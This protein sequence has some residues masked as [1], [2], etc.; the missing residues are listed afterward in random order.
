V[1]QFFDL[2]FAQDFGGSSSSFEVDVHSWPH[3][4]QRHVHSHI[5]TFRRR[6]VIPAR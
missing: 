1:F 4:S 6:I 5:V 3:R 2:H